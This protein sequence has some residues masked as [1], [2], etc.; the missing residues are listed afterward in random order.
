[1]L[2]YNELLLL[3]SRL[4]VRYP[5]LGPLRRR[6]RDEAETSLTVVHATTPDQ[7]LSAR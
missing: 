4:T 7:R 3:F 2:A 1:M 5:E 6:G